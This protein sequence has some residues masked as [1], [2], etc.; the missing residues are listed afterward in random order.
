MLVRT[1]SPEFLVEWVWRFFPL[2]EA[3]CQ[4]ARQESKRWAANC[5][6]TSGDDL[7]NSKLMSRIGN[8]AVDI[9]D[10]VKVS[11]DKDGAVSVEGPKGKLSW[12]LPNQIKGSV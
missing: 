1:K 2:R 5:W 9:P 6:P 7:L 11:V 3:F 10:K 12:K 4:G 8:K